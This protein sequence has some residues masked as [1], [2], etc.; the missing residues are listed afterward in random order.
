MLGDSDILKKM[1]KE[2]QVTCTTTE[3]Q[4]ENVKIGELV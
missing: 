3:S 2:Q 4:K 1:G